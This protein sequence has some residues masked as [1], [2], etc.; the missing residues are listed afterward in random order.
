CQCDREGA[1]SGLAEC[2]Q[3]TGQCPCKPHADSRT[4]GQCQDG[5]FA[6]KASSYL[7]CQ[8]CG[9]D[10]GGSL[11]SG[12]DAGTGACRCKKGVSGRSCSS[13]RQG[14]YFPGL[15]RLRV[16]LEDGRTPAGDP[17]RF[18]FDGAEFAN[19]SGRGYV[20]MSPLQEVVQ[21]DVE[22]G[23]STLDL[24][25][26]ALS[27]VST[28]DVPVMGRVTVTP[29][30]PQGASARSAVQQEKAVVF[31][32]GMGPG[33]SITEAI[34]LRPGSWTLIF[35]PHNPLKDHSLLLPSAGALAESP[36]LRQAASDPCSVSPTAAQRAQ[37]CCLRLTLHVAP[38]AAFNGDPPLCLSKAAIAA[39][40]KVLNAPPPL[41]QSLYLAVRAPVAGRYSLLLEYASEA[42]SE[43]VQEARVSVR[44]AGGVQQS[45]RAS[46]Q[47]LPCNY[48]FLC[49]A[50]A[51][52]PSGGV[53]S[54]DLPEQA[55]L[56]LTG[57]GLNFLLHKVYL[58]PV[59]RFSAALLEPRVHCVSRHGTY[60]PT[61]H[62]CL[63]S[64]FLFPAGSVRL[65]P[66]HDS[67]EK[68]GV[69]A[70]GTAAFGP[71][72]Q[73]RNPKTLAEGSSAEL[74]LLEGEENQVRMIVRVEKSGRHVFLLHYFQPGQPSVHTKVALKAS[75]WSWHGSFN[76]TFCP[77]A[78]GCRG[79]VAFESQLGVDLREGQEVSI[80]LTNPS[81]E[82]LWLA[83]VLAVPEHLFTPSVLREE[84]V[85]RSRDFV[86]VCGAHGF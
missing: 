78:Y 68:P 24:Y 65:A 84:P 50:V 44:D 72:P 7:G 34:V 43:S 48:S 86:T 54:Y 1:L 30:G 28:L 20:K 46:V 5:F 53:A 55:E 61:G 57:S 11:G 45:L 63:A 58:I 22:L 37:L 71:R 38:T 75:T 15:E 62:E 27:Y 79:V 19:F 66:T 23:P 40:L 70:S 14:Y 81:G 74:A 82:A 4:C 31:A 69:G 39:P 25:V 76:A 35:E 60:S 77:H 17:P 8:A 29:R 18:G 64:E 21:V 9:C 32:A 36:V 73:P 83:Y 49:R 3:E 12:C 85:D 13:P 80:T 26:V 10:M 52:D 51:L 33:R 59:H 56:H 47:I 42:E 2:T 6:L 41:Q 67:A 16:E